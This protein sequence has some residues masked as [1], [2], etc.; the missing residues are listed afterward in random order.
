MDQLR[1]AAV[2]AW[3]IAGILVLYPAL[4]VLQ[5]VWPIRLGDVGWRVVVAGLVSR[6]LVTP[7]LGLGLAFALAVWLKQRRVLRALSLVCGGV[8]VML[9]MGLGVFALDALQMRR[10]VATEGVQGNYDLGLVV[11]FLKYTIALG[12]LGVLAAVQWKTAQA[13]PKRV[14]I[15]RR[16]APALME[17]PH[18]GEEDLPLTAQRPA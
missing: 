7:I 4:D 3:I 2:P 12:L 5:A 16:A 13:M 17:H 14:R 1:K 6:V 9:V 8:A 15:R 10:M 11:S 18:G